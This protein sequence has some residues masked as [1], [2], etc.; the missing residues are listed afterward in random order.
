MAY[1]EDV[2]NA[3]RRL[4]RCPRHGGDRRDR[5]GSVPRRHGCDAAG[6]SRPPAHRRGSS[7]NDGDSR[8]FRGTLRHCD[9]P[10]FG[11]RSRS[12]D[13]HRDVSALA[14]RHATEGNFSIPLWQQIGDRNLFSL[15]QHHRD[16]DHTMSDSGLSNTIVTR[17]APRRPRPRKPKGRGRSRFAADRSLRPFQAS[18]HVGKA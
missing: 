17:P 9:R 7:G 5:S 18:Q 12:H 15:N 1:G 4:A 8:A 16:P 11:G 2:E 13:K 10:D 14:S 3:M 6:G